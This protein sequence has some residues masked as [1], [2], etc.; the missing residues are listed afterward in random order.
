MSL[1][2]PST[3]SHGRYTVGELIGRGGMAEVRKGIDTRLGRT[4]AIK[5]M[6]SDLTS[7]ETFLKRFHLEARSIALLNNP[8]IVSIFDTDEEEITDPDTGNTVRLPFIVMEYVKGQTLRD[9]LRVNGALSQRDSGQ[10][11]LGML[12]ALEYSH[13][14]GII[15]RDIK[16]GNIM[17]SEQGAVKVMDFGIARMLDDSAA[18]LTQSQG[19][20]GTAQYLSPEQARGEVVDTRSDLYSAGCVLYEMLTGRPPFTGDSAV[21]IAYQHVSERAQKPSELVPALN[22]IWDDV[23]AKAMMK[24]RTQRYATASQFRKDIATIAA[25]GTPVI[26]GI[27][28]P[29]A[30]HEAGTEPTQALSPTSEIPTNT[31]HTMANDFNDTQVAA[32]AAKPEAP[33][34]T[35]RTQ[36]RAAALAAKKKKRTKNIIITSVIVA[37]VALAAFLGWW[38]LGR[39]GVQTATVPTITVSMT[40]AQARERIESAGFTFVKRTDT[41]STAEKGT[42]TMQKPKGG[43]TAEKGSSVQVWFSAGP[44]QVSIPDVTGMTQD[45]AKKTL[46]D[47]GFIIG[48]VS[49]ED[50]ATVDKDHITRTD[51][52]ASS[53]A[54]KGS[55]IKLFIASGRVTVPTGLIGKT[56]NEATNTLTKSGFTVVVR[57]GNYSNTVAKGSVLDVDPSEGTS[58]DRGASVTITISK[59][60]KP[61]EKV[62]IDPGTYVNKMSFNDATEVL[63]TLGFKVSAIDGQSPDGNALVSEI[64]AD[65]VKLESATELSKS[66][67]ITLGVQETHPQD[68]NPDNSGDSNGDNAGDNTG[69]DSS[70]NAGN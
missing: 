35:S 50:S 11:M 3:L 41:D 31:A 2:T 17:I 54:A 12:N 14:M 56:Q 7:D 34:S 24:D 1:F 52:V 4:V 59:G 47:A 38:F 65:G 26:E 62:T 48:S 64:Y 8:N 18:T 63:S 39:N 66:A 32:L 19:V 68:E 15:H 28:Q 29:F 36:Q 21:S 30:A 25:G 10:I 20:V 22:P 49:S 60:K 43:S 44:Q 58:L 53:K 61:E 46:E 51:P 67:R 33:A 40:E 23:C 37:A 6:R 45:E 57:E 42:F 69:D 55:N 5:I 27:S 13:R 9:I 70:D 16:P